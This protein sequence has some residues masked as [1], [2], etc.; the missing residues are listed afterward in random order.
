MVILIRVAVSEVNYELIGW[1]P[2]INFLKT[3]SCGKQL[4]CL[5]MNEWQLNPILLYF[6]LCFK[7]VLAKLGYVPTIEYHL[8]CS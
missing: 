7:S 2:H 6:V 1:T 5:S 4:K 8:F 3:D